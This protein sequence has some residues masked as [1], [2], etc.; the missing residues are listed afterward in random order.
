MFFWIIIID[1]GVCPGPGICVTPAH[2]VASKHDT[3]SFGMGMGMCHISIRRLPSC[4]K[5][6]YIQ[7]N[8]QT[9]QALGALG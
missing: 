2:A 1:N 4:D 7:G 5:S 9:K 3:L 6:C 8:I